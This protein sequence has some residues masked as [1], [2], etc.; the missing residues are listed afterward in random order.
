M[1]GSGT[2]PGAYCALGCANANHAFAHSRVGNADA[3]KP[4]RAFAQA[5]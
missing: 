1:Q 4:P 5:T 3:K 2:L